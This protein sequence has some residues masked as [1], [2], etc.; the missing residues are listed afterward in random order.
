MGDNGSMAARLFDDM[1]AST[2]IPA[3]VLLAEEERSDASVACFD[4]DIHAESAGRAESVG[5][6]GACMQL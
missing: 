3:G 5:A 1:P 4:S 6:S 2:A